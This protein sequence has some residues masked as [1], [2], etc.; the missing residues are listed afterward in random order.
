MWSALG[1]VTNSGLSTHSPELFTVP[2]WISTLGVIMSLGKLIGLWIGT[3]VV[4]SVSIGIVV[5]VFL[6]LN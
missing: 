5:L 6:L 3:S 1:I 2:S 4:I